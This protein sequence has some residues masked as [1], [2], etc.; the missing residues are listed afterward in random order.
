MANEPLQPGRIFGLVA[1][2]FLA[3]VSFWIVR[4]FLSALLWAAIIAFS[5]W[6]LFRMLTDRAGLRPTLAA[7]VM[8]LGELLLVGVPV[9]FATPISAEDVETL[10]RAVERLLSEGLPGLDAQLATLPL[11]GPWLAAWMGSVDLGFDAVFALIRPYAGAAAQWLLGLLLAVLSGIAELFLA[12]IL[13]FFFYR[14][15]P[16]MA[17]FAE[18]VMQ[19]VGGQEARRLI[20]LVGDVTRGVIYGLVGTGFIQGVMTA[21]GLWIAGV[22]Q[23]VLLGVIA[24]VISLFPVGAPLVWIPASLWLFAQGSTGWGVFLAL[25]GAFGISSVDNIVRPWFISR[26]ADLPLLLTLI[27]ALGGVL[28]FGFLGLF[29]GPVV[30][31]VAYVLLRDWA[32]QASPRPPAQG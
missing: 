15:G 7:L 3:L 5:T 1:L 31:A 18:D 19:R 12:I 6:P 13:A 24:G 23:P 22:P 16:R 28:T 9:L 29:L 21:L 4:P 14:D 25:Y 26:G 20:R 8:V 17:A 27:G 32:S 30:L 10:R 11:A 2:A